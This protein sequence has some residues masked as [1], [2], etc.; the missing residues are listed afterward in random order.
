MMNLNTHDKITLF[1][2]RMAYLEFDLTCSPYPPITPLE[3]GK[4][5]G[6]KSDLASAI[7]IHVFHTSPCKYTSYISQEKLLI[8]EG[9]V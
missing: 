3:W 9:V 4:V 5:G 2:G 7:L 8:R 6:A 1:E